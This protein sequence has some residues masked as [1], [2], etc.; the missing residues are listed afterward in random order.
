MIKRFLP[1][2]LNDKKKSKYYYHSDNLT[3]NIT[4]II[5]KTTE[6]NI[7]YTKYISSIQ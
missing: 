3:Y 2:P 5:H 6:Y 1:F 4:H 7:V